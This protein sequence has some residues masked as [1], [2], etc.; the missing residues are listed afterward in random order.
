LLKESLRIDILGLRFDRLII[1]TFVI[2]LK[3]TFMFKLLSIFSCLTT[4]FLIS[5]E[6]V[7]YIE[8]EVITRAETYYE[9]ADSVEILYSD[10]AV[11][12][13]RIKA[14]LLYNYSDSKNPRREFPKGILVEFFDGNKN[15]QSRMTAKKAIQYDKTNKFIVED[16]VVVKSK[17]NEMIETEGLVWDES[18]QKIYS[19]RFITITTA[20]E[21][22]KGYGFESDYD[23]QNW[24]LKKV[25]GELESDRVSSGF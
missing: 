23:F 20:T 16:S 13:V 15:V 8:E 22:I 1:L 3:S 11:V 10:S 24:E 5:C 12:R 2:K 9:I 17:N 7:S 14:P 6:D 25:T 18:T 21:I 19:D 4:I